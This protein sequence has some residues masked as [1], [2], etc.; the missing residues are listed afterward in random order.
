MLSFYRRSVRIYILKDNHLIQILYCIIHKR[1]KKD[2]S[3]QSHYWQEVSIKPCSL[4]IYLWYSDEQVKRVH[5]KYNSGRQS[6]HTN[7]H[8]QSVPSFVEGFLAFLWVTVTNVVC[9]KTVSFKITNQ[10][11]AIRTFIKLTN[12]KVLYMYGDGEQTPLA[13]WGS[14]VSAARTHVPVFLMSSFLK[15]EVGRWCEVRWTGN[16]WHKYSL[17][18]P[19]ER[20]LTIK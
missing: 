17:L 20:V 7:L 18:Y 14:C 11:S 15:N 2:L 8:V 6:H 4:F 1:N 13:P 12:W 3:W 9:V 10:S 19:C 16:G 5:I